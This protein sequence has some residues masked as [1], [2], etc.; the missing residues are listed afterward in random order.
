MSTQ[1]RG[2]EQRAAGGR[3]GAFPSKQ[4]A[5]RNPIMT[6]AGSI[7]NWYELL[8]FLAIL[9]VAFASRYWRFFVQWL[10]GVRGR[11]WSMVS[12]VVD[13]VTVVVQTEQTRY[14][15]RVIGYLG[16][17]TYFYRNPELQTGDYCRMFDTEG[18]AQDWTAS[19]KGRTVMVHVDPRDPTRSVLRKEEL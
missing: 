4:R 16:T 18:E 5:G 19:Y 17:L 8:V 2:I 11:D 10:E 14:G 6:T 15:E 7:N 1:Y 3:L 9:A 13:I 12:A